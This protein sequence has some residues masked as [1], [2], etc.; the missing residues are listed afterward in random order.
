MERKASKSTAFT[1]FR[2]MLGEVEDS[3]W[4]ES[5]ERRSSN[6]FDPRQSKD[7]WRQYRVFS[8]YV[9]VSNSVRTP[10]QDARD[11]RTRNVI[12]PSSKYR[13]LCGTAGVSV[14]LKSGVLV[15]SGSSDADSCA[16]RGSS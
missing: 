3:C 7:R 4:A 13:C 1:S 2:G 10:G 9:D 12:L 8:T 16:E 5:C 11:A 6:S 14:D 15:F